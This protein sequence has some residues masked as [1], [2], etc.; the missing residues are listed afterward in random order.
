MAPLIT[1]RLSPP[2]RM[3]CAMM[4]AYASCTRVADAKRVAAA[5]GQHVKRSESGQAWII[6]VHYG[7]GRSAARCRRRGAA[8][9]GGGC[10]REVLVE[11][12]RASKGCCCCGHGAQ[13]RA[14]S[15][16][17]GGAGG[18]RGGEGRR[19]FPHCKTVTTNDAK[20]WKVYTFAACEVATDNR[21]FTAQLITSLWLLIFRQFKASSAELGDTDISYCLY[22]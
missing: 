11:N 22:S 10:G 20:T 6:G 8:L 19:A 1:P 21:F 9:R 17:S 2:Q 3:R 12:W 5:A 15:V 16:S 14:R 4:R 7:R 13:G 18:G